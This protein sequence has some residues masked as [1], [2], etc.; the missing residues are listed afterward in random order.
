M[1]WSSV[2]L[3]GAFA[4]A[5]LAQTSA[6]R[7]KFEVVSI[8]PTDPNGPEGIRMRQISG[9]VL[10]VEGYGL[11][12]LVELAFGVKPYQITGA[13]G[14]V[15]SARYDINAKAT[16]PVSAKEMWPMMLPVL[17]ERFQLQVHREKKEMPVY[18]LSVAKSGKLADPQ[19]NC[20]D[21]SG[22]LPPLVRPQPG[23]RP[24][25]LC[26]SILPPISDAASATLRGTKIRM[27]T[28]V[29]ALTDLLGRPVVDGTGFTGTFDLELKFDRDE[30]AGLPQRSANTVP[31]APNIFTALQEQLGLKLDSGRDAVEVIV[32]DRIERP[33]EN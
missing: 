20:F 33:S 26:D 16:A 5:G 21:P 9:G 11:P 31:T 17:E 28:L 4:A 23:Q 19:A 13:P 10:N 1:S 18:K 24:L 7:P 6:E 25:P 29:S 22:P 2:L 27:A 32:I 8:R 3:I 14:W 30:S 12:I 15:K